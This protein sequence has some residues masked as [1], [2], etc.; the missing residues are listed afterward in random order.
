M[1]LHPPAECDELDGR[2]DGLIVG[3]VEGVLRVAQLVLDP[4]RHIDTEPLNE[5]QCLQRAANREREHDRCW[6]EVT[7]STR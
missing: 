7:S 5:L 4:M 6:L 3:R 2:C 1:E